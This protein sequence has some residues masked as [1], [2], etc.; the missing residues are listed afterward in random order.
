MTQ[1]FRLV[2]TSGGAH[3]E[4]ERV[5]R[6]CVGLY[7][8]TAIASYPGP[9]NFSRTDCLGLMKPTEESGTKNTKNGNVLQRHK[10]ISRSFT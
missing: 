6:C 8:N 7:T 3:L 10:S 5:A 2:G 9:K 4:V 1:Q